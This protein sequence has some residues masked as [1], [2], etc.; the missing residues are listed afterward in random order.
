MQAEA[1]NQ[2][3]PFQ[4][5]SMTVRAVMGD[6]GE[7]WF[8][9]SDICAVIDVDA[10]AVRKLD[11]D[12]R[13]LRSVQTLGGAQQVSI[14]SESGMYTLVL[15]CRDAMKSDTRPYR[16]RKWV[17]AE[18]LPTIRKTGSYNAAP[19]IDLNDPAFLRSTL[20]TYTEKVIALE[21]KIIEQEPKVNALRRIAEAE[22]SFCISDAAKM[23][24]M[25]P[26]Q[27][28]TRLNEM[29]W[30][31]KR[32]GCAVWLGY[33]D[34]TQAGLLVHKSTLV[35]REDG[36]EKVAEQVRITGRGI[37]RVATMLG[38][39]VVEVAEAAVA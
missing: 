9:A 32:P 15:R 14:V 2:L 3:V 26:K 28:F 37:A 23:L 24:Q 5:E 30:I 38:A 25:P 16:F 27:L 4:F 11:D 18:V 39:T 6:D 19:A 34:K 36:T 12:E 17:T 1:V 31:F 7:P 29:R 20:L 10:T 8:I 13:G 21:A 22:G 33:Q 35:T